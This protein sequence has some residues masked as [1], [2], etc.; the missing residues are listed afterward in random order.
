MNKEQIGWK[1]CMK[2]MGRFVSPVQRK[3]FSGS[4]DDSVC[5]SNLFPE[6]DNRGAC[7]DTARPGRVSEILQGVSGAH[8]HFDKVF[9]ILAL[10]GTSYV[11]RGTGAPCVG[12][13]PDQC[14]SADDA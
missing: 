13:F 12:I 5:D 7:N 3:I 6:S 10:L 1:A 4:P 8:V 14:D 9:R 11:T 2:G